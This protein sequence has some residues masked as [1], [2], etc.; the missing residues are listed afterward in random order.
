MNPIFIFLLP[1]VRGYTIDKCTSNFNGNCF[2]CVNSALVD[3]TCVSFSLSVPHCLEYLPDGKCK[4]CEFGFRLGSEKCQKIDENDDCILYDSEQT[5]AF[6]REGTVLVS[7]K[8]AKDRKCSV[9]NCKL[10]EVKNKTQ[11][12]SFCDRGFTLLQVREGVNICIASSGGL[13]DCWF[14][15]TGAFCD[16]CY[17]NYV[18]QPDR[19]CLQSDQYYYDYEWIFNPPKAEIM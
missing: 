16:V 8:C 11:F 3:H 14:T 1:L 12:C 5:C 15:N 7:G 18:M 10:C 6:C 19:R 13:K 17:V 2:S 4:K 9:A